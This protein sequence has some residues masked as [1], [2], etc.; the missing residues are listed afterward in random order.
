MSAN[1]VVPGTCNPN[2]PKNTIVSL[3]ETP[4]GATPYINAEVLW[5]LMFANNGERVTGPMSVFGSVLYFA[6]YAPAAGSVCANGTAYIWG[7]DY[8]QAQGGVPAAGGVYR[9]PAS[10]PVAPGNVSVGNILVPGITIQAQLNCAAVGSTSDYYGSRSSLNFTTGVSAA[11]PG[12][13]IQASSSTGGVIGGIGSGL[14]AISPPQP[15][16]VDSWGAVIE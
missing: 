8:V 6:T 14:Q 2:P 4:V 3:R 12:F 10:A 7:L 13:A 16:M 11:Q 9:Y 5:Y 15:A 1:C